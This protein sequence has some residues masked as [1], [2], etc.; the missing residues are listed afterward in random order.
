[1]PVRTR[2]SAVLDKAERRLA[3]LKS[4][5]AN[6]DLGHGLNLESYDQMISKIRNTIEAHNTLLSEIEESR[7]TI[8]QMERVLS[9]LST[10]LLSGIATRYGRGS[11][12]YLK[13]GGSNGTRRRTAFRD[14]SSA[15][16]TGSTSQSPSEDTTPRVS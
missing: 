5:D 11:I 14:T 7:K 16:G 8:A 13:A 1:M 2:G 15:E 9:D 6:L 12:E 3:S 10:R 4:I